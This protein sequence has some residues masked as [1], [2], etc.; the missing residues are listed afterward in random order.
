M[1]QVYKLNMMITTALLQPIHGNTI[2]LRTQAVPADIAPGLSFYVYS[3]DQ[4]R[5]LI[6][7]LP[8]GITPT[9]KGKI[10]PFARIQ[11][12]TGNVPVVLN[13][14]QC[15]EPQCKRLMLS[16]GSSHRKCHHDH[17][18]PMEKFY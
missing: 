13:I 3:S 12:E 15:I 4:L 18:H 11:I 7:M 5:K 10:I 8:E 9:Q 1:L 14:K 2:D 17:K 6:N 16:S